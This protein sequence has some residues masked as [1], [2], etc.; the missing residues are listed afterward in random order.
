MVPNRQP[1]FTRDYS[2]DLRN[3]WPKHVLPQ[4]DVTKPL[5]WL[6][7]GSFEG[8]SAWW[9]LENILKHEDSRIVCVDP[10]TPWMN[11][12]GIPGPFDFEKTFD[13][14]L[15][16]HPQVVKMRAASSVALP[17]LRPASFDGC[18]IDGPHDYDSVIADAH[19][20]IPLLKPNAILAFDDYGGDSYPGVR[21]AVTELIGEWGH[22]AATLVLDVQAIFK[23]L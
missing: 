13:E 20:A 21:Q 16:G 4:L 22:K 3:L 10:W 1:V 15:K 18:Y 9:T 6:E 2:W 7:I 12:E 23:I 17:L 5:A 14:N 19:R 8:R 11:F